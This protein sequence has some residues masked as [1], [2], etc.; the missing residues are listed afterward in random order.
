MNVLF[1]IDLF[2][3]VCVSNRH[4]LIDTVSMCLCVVDEFIRL[5]IVL[6][7]ELE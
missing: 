6:D 3:P 2:V 7:N 1:I 4:C 5:R